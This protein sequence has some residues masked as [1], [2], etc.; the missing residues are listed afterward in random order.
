MLKKMIP[1]GIAGQTVIVDVNVKKF[2]INNGVEPNAEQNGRHF[3]VV[4]GLAIQ[5][6]VE[7]ER[8]K[9][10]FENS[11]KQSYIGSPYLKKTSHYCFCY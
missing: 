9:L 5:V 11:D 7:C 10:H 1:D 4:D 6:A 8:L 3:G 2:E